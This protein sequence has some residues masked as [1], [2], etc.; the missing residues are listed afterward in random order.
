MRLSR[1]R[2]QRRPRILRL[3][4]RLIAAPECDQNIT[5]VQAD[6]SA[7]L[8]SQQPVRVVRVTDHLPL[9]RAPLH[10]IAAKA[11][12]LRTDIAPGAAALT[13]AQMSTCSTNTYRSPGFAATIRSSEEYDPADPSSFCFSLIDNLA[14]LPSKAHTPRS[15][16]QGRSSYALPDE[17]SSVAGRPVDHPHPSGAEQLVDPSVTRGPD[18]DP[19]DFAGDNV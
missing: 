12:V 6:A 7:S 14:E 5:K 16:V 9:R 15:Q 3:V 13:V 8:P 18:A 2:S 17:T 11:F 1:P 4:A 10:P 19:S